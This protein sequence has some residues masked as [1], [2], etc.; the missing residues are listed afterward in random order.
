MKIDNC[1]SMFGAKRLVIA[2]SVATLGTLT[3][4]GLLVDLQPPDAPEFPIW[5]LTAP[6][7]DHLAV[8]SRL[9]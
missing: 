9:T 3:G 7:C 5:E 4:S 6:A 2:A 8:L 1:F